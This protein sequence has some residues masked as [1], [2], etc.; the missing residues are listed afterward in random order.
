MPDWSRRSALEAV[1]AAGALALAGC[2]DA[3]TRTHNHPPEV[4][5]RITD[6]EAIQVRSH[7]PDPLFVTGEQPSKTPNHHDGDRNRHASTLQH[8]TDEDD[9]AELR[10]RDVAGAA[11]LKSFVTNT[12]LESESVYLLQRS[13]GECYEPRLVGVYRKDTGIDAKFCRELLPADVECNA[14]A[15]DL[16]A[17]AIRL[18][19]A[20]DEFTGLGIGSSS[21][22]EHLATVPIPKGGDSA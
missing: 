3:T 13:I 18:P 4:R 11:D 5:D 12:D 20:G 7:G 15:D 8:L 16:I 21:S 2:S 6:F 17:I 1:A 10:F 9:I 14:D 22:C 19:F